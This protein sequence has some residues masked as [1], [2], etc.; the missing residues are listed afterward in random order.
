MNKHFSSKKL[1][2]SVVLSVGLIGTLSA[3]DVEVLKDGDRISPLNANANQI[4]SYNSSIKDAT[5]AVVNITTEK[6][7]SLDSRAGLNE[8]N[9]FKDPF[10]RQFFGDIM[11][12]DRMQGGIG[13]G[14]IISND[15]YIVTNSHVVHGADKI[16]VNISGKT[17]K[18][19]AKLVGEDP[20]SDI[21]VI[22]IDVKNLPTLK[23]TD[24]SKSLVGDVVFAIGNPFGVGES[25][26]QGIISALN[27][28]GMGIS[29]Y[30]NFIQTDA[31]INPGNSGGA[32]IDSRG[33]LIGMNT[34]II[35][36]TGGNHGIGFAIP[37]NMVKDIAK[38]LIEKGKVV[39]GFL[40]VQIKDISD[41]MI[42][43]YNGKQGALVLGIDA[44]SPAKK[45]GLA[46]WDLITAVN[47][48]NVK[49]AS[50]LT[51]T[52]GQ[53]KP[54]T[55]INLTII[56]NKKQ[57]T[58]KVKLAEKPSKEAKIT[59]DKT[60]PSNGNF[61]GV[62]VE[63]LTERVKQ[64]YQIP[65]DIS[66]VIV[67]QVEN[68]SKAM[69]LGFEKGDIITQIEDT[70]INSVN[71]FKKAINTYKGKAQRILIYSLNGGIKTLIFN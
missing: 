18:Y 47:G 37:S 60:K 12:E 67:S 10:F 20:Q 7:V 57:Q 54:N 42:N 16:I 14:V 24:S 30:E 52:I 36:R 69:M 50:E 5:K 45:A 66:G 31:S 13:S 43:S 55:Q 58:I 64:I 59:K 4:Y 26:T 61:D 11:P 27:K 19:K 40:G 23:F 21:A 29:N 3:F 1:F 15:G 28:H 71:D 49:N 8:G 44:N 32:L 34:A 9:P 2:L 25:V 35:S 22:K 41:D 48:K 70:K 33:A 46:V 62:I 39:R 65:K 38:Q 53:I 56:R 68:G 6:K 51:N 17:Q 63:N